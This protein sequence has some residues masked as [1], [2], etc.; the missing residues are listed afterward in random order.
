MLRNMMKKMQSHVS[1]SL[2]APA[3][4]FLIVTLTILFSSRIFNSIVASKL[5]EE[6]TKEVR[7][8]CAV[9]TNQ[10]MS[11]EMR[12]YSMNYPKVSDSSKIREVER[13][14]DYLGAGS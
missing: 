9:L 10:I 14:A 4:V 11:G 2:L 13:L 1:L 12:S 8:H 6:Q 5:L 7:Q 3:L